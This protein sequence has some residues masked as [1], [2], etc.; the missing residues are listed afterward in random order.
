MN[1]SETSTD[2]YD[3]AIIGYGPTGLA[4]AYWLGRAGH[5]VVV[6]ERWPELYHLPR[7]AH[8]D[9]EIMRLFQRMGMAEEIAAD[10]SLT[11]RTV[12][13]DSDGELLS[14]SPMEDCDQGW[15]SHY[16]LFQP[17]LERTIDAGVRQ[18]QNVTVL[19]G[20]Q[21]ESI[22]KREND[23]LLLDIVDGTAD[24][25]TWTPGE[26]RSTI[27]A[28][29][30]IGADGANSSVAEFMDSDP[31]DLGYKAR[32]LVIFAERLD[33][34][35]GAD[36]P[37]SEVGML[38]SRPYAAWRE[39]GR[40]YARWEFLVL[41]T[42]T[43]EEMNTEATAWKLIEP[44]GFSP[45]TAKLVRNTVFEFRTILSRRW[46]AGRV[47]LAGDSAHR[48]PPFQGQGMCS[49]QR[50][51]AALA[52]R[53]DLVL[54]GL[55]DP[56]LL[57]SYQEERLPHVRELIMNSAERGQQFWLTDP[58][59]ARERDARMREGLV[60]SNLKKN[61][62]AVPSLTAGCLQHSGGRFAG[63]AGS[64]SPQF[65]VNVEGDRVLLDDVVRSRWSLIV[66][67]RETLAALDP[68]DLAALAD[69]GT[70]IW[71]LDD[72]RDDL[73]D[74]DGSYRAWLERVEC[75]AVLVRPDS[76]IFG[77]AGDAN[78]LLTTV[79]SALAQLHLKQKVR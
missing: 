49:G 72:E 23:S 16:S 40:R 31:E 7:A 46:R 29:W 38:L 4:T 58:V 47:L 61:Y 53:L 79:R 34:S 66:Q 50:D 55:A 12:V 43:T 52:W 69:V 73:D 74:V 56:T 2:T 42:E 59:L 28:R 18:T 35:V 51:A 63:L 21:L 44:W 13:R 25:G 78:G 65:P 64:L 30:V 75:E 8:V 26:R 70:R 20:W 45:A 24:K 14:D 67:H 68:A 41:D 15:H 10:S 1:N 33:R 76:Y 54:R 48:M 37:D 5:K 57:D 6:I 11:C 3:V 17:N 36:M 9:G 77:G 71:V 22:T 27:N 60:R 39:S 19:Q 62:G 32:A